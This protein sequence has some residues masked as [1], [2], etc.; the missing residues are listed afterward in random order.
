VKFI[1]ADDLGYREVGAYGSIK[2]K[3]RNIE[4]WQTAELF[5][6]SYASLATYYGNEKQ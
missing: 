1:Y 2:L 5:K 4:S 3:T 6:N